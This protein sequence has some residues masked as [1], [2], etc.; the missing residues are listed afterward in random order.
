MRGSRSMACLL[1]G[2]LLAPAK[3]LQN[4]TAETQQQ[5]R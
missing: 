4:T 2:M 3:P 5:Q 1:P